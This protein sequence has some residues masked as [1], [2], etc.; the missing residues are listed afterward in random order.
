M[1]DPWRRLHDDDDADDVFAAES[2]RDLWRV[3][4]T[5]WGER[6]PQH[7]ET[8]TLLRKHHAIDREGALDTALLLCTD[9]RWERRS[10]GVIT[11]IVN[12]DV[13]SET[14]LD[15]L[16]NHFLWS[17]RVTYDFPLGWLGTSF[18]VVDLDGDGS[19]D[20]GGVGETLELDPATPVPHH[21]RI[22]PPLR[23]WA[24]ARL[25]MRRPE[26]AGELAT[27]ARDMTDRQ[28]AMAV[29]H[30]MLDSVEVL[31]DDEAGKA[32][33]LGLNW[34]SGPLRRHALQL[35]A[36]RDGIDVARHLA[37]TDTDASVRRWGE[38]LSTDGQPPRSAHRRATRNVSPGSEP[39]SWL[40]SD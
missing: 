40:F 18:V 2:A 12:A 11:D 33:A 38:Q 34:P 19:A 4:V 6:R 7:G 39:Q 8:A 37:A 30:G 20:A 25:V 3:L 32:I 9:Q 29:V 1:S 27:L 14:E 24:A 10:A 35:L 15:E 36:R 13:L 31:D 23:R 5:R 17:E 21:R 22:N 16:A 28:G 26:R